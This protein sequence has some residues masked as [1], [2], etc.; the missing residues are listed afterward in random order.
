MALLYSQTQRNMIKQVSHF[1]HNPLAIFTCTPADPTCFLCYTWCCAHQFWCR[2][3]FTGCCSISRR[4][5]GHPLFPSCKSFRQRQVCR[6]I[7]FR[8]LWGI[9]SF[10][11][12]SQS[13]CYRL[14]GWFQ[15]CLGIVFSGSGIDG[16]HVYNLFNLQK[17]MC[18]FKLLG[19]LKLS[20]YAR[21]L[22]TKFWP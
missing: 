12:G 20:F 9:N 8:L 3:N 15:V 14:G 6:I 2:R 13:L 11:P 18:S 17:K 7:N 22:W 10:L 5:L 21:P 16:G 1:K 4:S 19:N